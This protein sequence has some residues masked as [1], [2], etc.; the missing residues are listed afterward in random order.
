MP[1]PEQPSLNEEKEPPLKPSRETQIQKIAELMAAKDQLTQPAQQLVLSIEPEAAIQTQLSP[2]QLK[3]KLDVLEQTLEI[4]EQAEIEK[5]KN[6]V[7][8]L[9][10][11]LD[12]IQSRLQQVSI[13]VDYFEE[14]IEEGKKLGDFTAA[15][16]QALIQK[17]KQADN[18]EAA[19]ILEA[20]YNALLDSIDQKNA[21]AQVLLQKQSV[22]SELDEQLEWRQVQ[23]KYIDSLPELKP[24]VKEVSQ[25]L[26]QKLLSDRTAPYAN[27]YLLVKEA[28][29]S[30]GLSEKLGQSVQ[31]SL[32][33]IPD[34]EIKNKKIIPAQFGDKKHYHL[35]DIKNM[36]YRNLSES[37]IQDLQQAMF[38]GR[39]LD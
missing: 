6:A 11:E 3:D 28:I 34:N 4:D 17:Y 29:E 9:S 26:A 19:N 5:L 30:L 32:P 13:P 22:K 37:D 16:I 1:F 36:D 8:G 2:L 35:N 15:E 24:F 20:K 12:E 7:L 23:K 31:P 14:E 38:E 10:Q 33:N 25:Y 39:I 27:K 18:F 21:L